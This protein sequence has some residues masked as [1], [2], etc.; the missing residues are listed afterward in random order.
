MRNAFLIAIL[1]QNIHK[2]VPGFSVDS[3]PE[4]FLLPWAVDAGRFKEDR[5]WVAPTAFC[6]SAVEIRGSVFS[7]ILQTTCCCCACMVRKKHRS[8]IVLRIVLRENRSKN[9]LKID[10]GILNGVRSRSH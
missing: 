3:R 5:Y 2:T 4:P 6:T 9:L 10:W 8:V 7:A 1:Q